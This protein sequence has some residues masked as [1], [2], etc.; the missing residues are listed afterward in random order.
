MK[1]SETVAEVNVSRENVGELK[2]KNEKE[3]SQVFE[4]TT[5]ESHMIYEGAVLNLRRDKVKV[6]GGGIGYREIV[7]HT[8]GVTVVALTNEEKIVL[9]RQFRKA[10]EKA[11]L[12]LPAGKLEEG[13]D[14]LS[15][16]SRELKEETGY[17]AGKIQLLSSFYVAIGYSQEVI[18]LYLATEL[19]GGERDLDPDEAIEIH[20][21][22]LE[23]VVKMCINGE[24]QDSKVLVGA[25][26]V[27]EILR[28]QP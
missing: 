7:E 15:G 4:E 26:M 19:V 9:V 11:V 13:E 16:I 3:T 14:P 10:A 12:E 20:E 25:L 18:H 8:G 28:Q 6:V 5:L 23:D 24:I 17:T 2:V 27:N 21:Y 22:P 1:A